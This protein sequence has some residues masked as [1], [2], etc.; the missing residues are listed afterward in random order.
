MKMW[1]EG[2]DLL[3]QFNSLRTGCWLLLHGGEA[4]VLELP[5]AGPGEPSP[6]SLVR[7]AAHE[8]NL[9]V[10]YILCTHGHADH[11]SGET[12]AQFRKHFPNAAV[13]LQR[14]IQSEFEYSPEIHWFDEEMALDLGGEP[15]FLVHAPKHSDADTMVIFRGTMCTGDWELDTIRSVHDAWSGVSVDAKLA[16]IG[17]LLKWTRDHD[18]HIR[19]TFSVHANDKREN[20]DFVGLM[21]NTQVDRQLW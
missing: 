8:Q 14:K 19:R 11:L 7:T 13:C 4:A 17:R 21:K 20:V 3:G 16:S 12:L 15:L 2:I 18:Y 10:K 1:F 9:T 5:P 6:V